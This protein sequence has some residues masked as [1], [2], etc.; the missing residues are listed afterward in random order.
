MVNASGGL[1]QPRF[2]STPETA[3]KLDKIE[4]SA[5]QADKTKCRARGPAF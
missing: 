4:I 1:K 3:T 5:A 2:E